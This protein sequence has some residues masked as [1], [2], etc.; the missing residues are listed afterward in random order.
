VW[1]VRNKIDPTL[2]NPMGGGRT[3]VDVAI[4]PAGAMELQN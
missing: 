1:V 3:S 2:S 4:R